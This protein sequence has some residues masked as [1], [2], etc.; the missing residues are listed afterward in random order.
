M[1]ILILTNSFIGLCKFRKELIEELEKKHDVYVDIP[2]DE[3]RR[4]IS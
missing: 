3:Y 4:E 1:K 2:D